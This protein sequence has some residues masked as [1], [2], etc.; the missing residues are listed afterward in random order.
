MP[1]DPKQPPIERMANVIAHEIRNPLAVIK[2]SAYFVKMKLGEGAEA[3]VA[4]HI[5]L[6]EAEVNRAN[7][8]IEDMLAFARP[9]EVHPT[10]VS[11]RD[12]V[13]G[14]LALRKPPAKVK[15]AVE[16]S[17][18]VKAKVDREVAQGAVRRLLENAYDALGD[19]G[20]S[21]AVRTSAGNGSVEIVVKD[22]GPGLTP[23][24]KARLFEPFFSTRPRGLGI[25]LA[26][27]RKFVERH[28]GSIELVEG[29]SGASFRVK[30][31]AA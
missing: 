1:S 30:L 3:K 15:V 20:G 11:A 19:G 12:V 10:V 16:G 25:G 28:G 17:K 9:L 13:E 2:N 23:E 7:S 18:D 26:T 8:M 31:P 14:A 29:G 4:K 5:G 6:I 21:V 27:A 24:A 22:S